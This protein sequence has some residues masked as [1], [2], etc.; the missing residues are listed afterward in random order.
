MLLL[1][2]TISPAFASGSVDIPTAGSVTQPFLSTVAPDLSGSYYDKNDSLQSTTTS[3][4]DGVDIQQTYGS[5]CTQNV[6]PIYAAAA[7]TVIYADYDTSGFGWSVRIDHGTSA[8]S[9]GKYVF[10]LYGHM[11]TADVGGNPGT[12]CI[13][14]SQNQT[15]TKGQLIGYQGTSGNSTGVHLHW[16]V[17]A[18]PSVDSFSDSGTHWASPDFYTC[19]PLTVSLNTNPS[20]TANV[21]V[22]ENYC[23]TNNSPSGTTKDQIYGMSARGT[24]SIWAAGWEQPSGANKTPVTYFNNGSGWTKYSPSTV[25]SNHHYLYGIAQS[26]SGDTWTVGKLSGSPTSTLAYHWTG[27]SWTHVTSDNGNA[28]S[29]NELFGVAI[30]GGGTPWAVGDY[31]DGTNIQP[32]LEQWNG[33]KFAKQTLTMPTNAIAGQLYGVAF[34][35]ST[36]GWAVGYVAVGPGPSYTY[37]YVIYHYDGTSWTPSTGTPT[38]STQ[39]GLTSVTAISDNEAWATGKK[40]VSGVWKPLVMHYTSANGWQE[41][42]SFSSSFPSDVTLYSVSG[43][44]PYNVWVVGYSGTA[45]FTM[46]FDGTVWSQVSTPSVTGTNN[47]SAVAVSS[48]TAWAGGGNLVSG[49]SYPYPLIF[50]TK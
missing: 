12:S 48:G 3:F 1:S 20:P 35:S 37:P 44:S 6:S 18:N 16:S 25:N 28:T 11:G 24:S 31:N 42:T 49:Q 8:S 21:V 13:V 27:S 15:V 46:H 50:N 45:L 17:L 33:T 32:L 38:G 26:S 41:D 40:K 7:G 29:T 47:L 14:V 39:P 36:N 43:D 23:W 30:D 2:A 22:G 5:D 9:N 10:T 34:S 19:V 4:H